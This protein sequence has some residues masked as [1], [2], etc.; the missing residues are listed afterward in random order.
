[1]DDNMFSLLNKIKYEKKKKQ[2]FVKN[3]HLEIDLVKIK[4]ANKAKNL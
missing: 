2:N 3:K 4:N 1:M